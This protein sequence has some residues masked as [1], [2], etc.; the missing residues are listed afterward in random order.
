[1]KKFIAGQFRKPRGLFGWLAS[2]MMIKGNMQ[3][4]LNLITAMELRG[5]EK[6]FEIGY[7]PGE[8]MR[9]ILIST[10]CSIDGIDFSSLMHSKA[11]K[12]NMR[13]IRSGR[14]SLS[15]GDI[16]DHTPTS[17]YDAVFFVNVI[18]F[19]KDLMPY[20]S[21]IRGMLRDGG[22]ISFYMA[23]CEELMKMPFTATDIF[24]KHR[25]DDV[26]KALEK[27]GFEEIRY[28][29]GHANHFTGHCFVAVKQS[30]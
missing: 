26:G 13:F 1:M 12:R 8:G 23:D 28:T 3:A 9:H 20:F 7:G 16:L 5:N 14:A 24:S 4:Y 21:K 22:K 19:W 27:C 29:T 10:G 11:S 15:H 18:Y 2:K 6:L 17:Q 25:A 30:R